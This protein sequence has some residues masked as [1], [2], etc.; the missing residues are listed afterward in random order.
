M[1]K[2]GLL[3]FLLFLPTSAFPKV[4]YIKVEGPIGPAVA[5]FIEEALEVAREE[6]SNLLIIL[7]DTPGGIDASMRDIIKV[8][9]YS[10]VP[11]VV[12]VFPP[13]ARAA[14]AGTFILM[15]SH[16]A[17]MAPGTSIG[18]A[19]PV[20]LGGR[21]VPKEMQE[22]LVNDA[23]S[24]IKSL[25][26]KHGRNAKWAE[27]AVRKSATLT[28]GEAL[29]KRVIEV[30]A[31]SV[32]E[33]LQK[34]DGRVVKTAFGTVKIKVKGKEIVEIPMNARL[35]VLKVLSDPNIAYI[36]LMIGMWGIF[37][38][39]SHPGTILPGVIGAVSLVLGLFALQTLPVNWAG[40]A[41]ILLGLILFILELKIT[42]YGLL[43][44]GGIA[45][46]ALG[47]LMLFKSP[48]PFLRAS[49]GVIIPSVAT[50]SCFFIFAI[51]MA[52][53]AQLKK[54]MLG[55]EG[56]SG[57]EGIAL[58]DLIPSGKV[59]VAGEYWDAETDGQTIRKGEKIKVKGSKGFKLLVLKE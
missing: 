51:S 36:L 8:I 40:L 35:R 48:D 6:S 41:L 59:L 22:K 52:L 56:L 42:S 18:A 16:I 37:F 10:P 57:K 30:I 39:L 29:R 3:T 19:H 11:V 53:K 21:K 46:L 58:T 25:A 15:A 54:P 26:R 33:L 45:C 55:F 43:T 23:V 28:P 13:G 9:E 50:T 4:H 32:E 49:W 34:V 1:R 17:A 24:Y 14:S 44:F 12:F 27:L 7:L 20:M 38:E 5:D 2:V 47:S 31:S